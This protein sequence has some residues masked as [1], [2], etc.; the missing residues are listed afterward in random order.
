MDGLPAVD[1][2]SDRGALRRASSA[3]RSSSTT[4][5]DEWSHFSYVDGA[6]IV[7]ME[8]ELCEKADI[9]F[10]TARTLSKAQAPTT[11]RP[12]SRPTAWTTT[13]F[14]KAL[15]PETKIAAEIARYRNRSSGSSGS[16]RSGSISTSSR[17]RREA[18]GR[19]ASSSSARRS[20]DIS[21]LQVSRTS[22]C[23]VASR[24]PTLPSYCKGFDVGAHPVRRST[25]SR[26]VN[27]I[28]LREYL[29]AGLPVVSTELPEVAFYKDR[30]SVAKTHDE[31]MAGI[32]KELRECYSRRERS[33]ATRCRTRRGRRRWSSLASRSRA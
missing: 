15:L 30:C 20:V 5:L 28:K 6:K 27:P 12:T 8:K 26:A 31:F 23:S 24:T 14:A 10:A 18:P 25:S 13:H 29:S 4:A 19:A 16:F 7:A 3:N 9:V 17:A 21:R 32:V 22:T 2:S 1:A 33:A 11:P